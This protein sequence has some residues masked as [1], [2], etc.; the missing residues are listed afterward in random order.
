MRFVYQQ[1]VQ[2]ISLFKQQLLHWLKNEQ[3]F[4]YL[5]NNEFQQY[6][7]HHFELLVGIGCHIS[8]TAHYSNAFEQLNSFFQQQ[9]D[10]LFGHLGY[11]LKNETEKLSSE[12]NDGLHFPDLFFFQPETVIYIK[13]NSLVVVVESIQNNGAVIFSAINN[14]QP[15]EKTTPSE[16]PALQTKFSKS[17]YLAAVEKIKEHIA[18]GDFYEMNLCMEFFAKDAA[19]Q[20]FSVFNKLN[21]IN[22]APFSAL[23]KNGTQ[24]LICSSPERF[25]MKEADTLMSQPIKGTTKRGTN[26]ADDALKKLQLQNDEKERAEN[27]MIVDLVRNDLAKS[28]VAGS[29]EVEELFKVYTFNQVHHLISTIKG[30]LKQNVTG[31][32][33]I[34]NAFPM[35][36]MTGA[37]KVIVM[38]HIEQYE[39][40]RRGLYS[41]SVGYFTPQ[42]NFDFNVVIRSILFNQ[43]ASYIS[44]QVGSAITFDSVAEK[45]YDECMLK[46][47]AMM[48][49]LQ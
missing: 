8:I 49:A 46:A 25:L 45:E 24:Y 9:N 6:Q 48:K 7:H 14:I 38:Q 40:T 22:A 29:V 17:D 41:G 18:Q 1:E 27:V 26:E 36:S 4:C 3:V 30:N 32:A 35:G 23:Y 19:L 43:A 31:V 21:K 37:P 44:F 10:W 34:K 28:C 12:N 5:D 13:P 39:K 20:P 11:D 2:H 47:D 42:G 33:A 15:E 16:L